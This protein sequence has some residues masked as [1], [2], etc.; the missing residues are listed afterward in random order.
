MNKQQ[1]LV[2]ATVAAWVL[3]GLYALS[4]IDLVPD[5]IPVVGWI[6][7]GMGLFAVVTLTALTVAVSLLG[8]ARGAPR[9]GGGEVIDIA[10]EPLSPEQIKAL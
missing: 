1:A 4:P 10:Y 7:D 3:E 9:G 6:D 5:F 8:K 2:A